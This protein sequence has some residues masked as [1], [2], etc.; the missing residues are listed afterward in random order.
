MKDQ[1]IA[2]LIAGRVCELWFPHVLT[3]T[4][5]EDPF[6]LSLA[7]ALYELSSNPDIVQKLRTEILALYV[8]LVKI[9]GLLT[10]N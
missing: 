9:L 6:G 10:S 3:L 1:L 4:I 5:F 2:V 7:W 8:S